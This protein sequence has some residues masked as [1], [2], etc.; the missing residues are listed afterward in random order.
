MCQVVE[1]QRF[2]GLALMQNDLRLFLVGFQ[3]V[4]QI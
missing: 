3:I 1:H 4:V 2:L